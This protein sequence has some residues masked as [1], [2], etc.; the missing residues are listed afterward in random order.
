MSLKFSRRRNWAWVSARSLRS[1]CNQLWNWSHN[2]R[3][4]IPL[5]PFLFRYLDQSRN[6][7]RSRRSGTF[8][9]CFGQPRQ[10]LRCHAI[11]KDR[12]SHSS[13]WMDGLD[14]GFWWCFG[15]TECFWWGHDWQ[16]K[17]PFPSSVDSVSGAELWVDAFSCA[18]DWFLPEWGYG[19][20]SHR[21]V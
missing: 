5:I 11:R 3:S 19:V 1:M 14:N 13:F 12:H 15:G 18:S 8:S 20:E 2:W 16:S 4:C 17:D 9:D 21:L 6:P 10:C 7:I